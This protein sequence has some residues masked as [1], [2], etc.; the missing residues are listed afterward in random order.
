MSS[1]RP[2]RYLRKNLHRIHIFWETK[3]N[4]RLCCL[5][6]RADCGR[7][8]AQIGFEVLRNLANETLKRQLADEKL[9]RLLIATNFAK[10]N[11]ARAI[12]V[13]SANKRGVLDVELVKCGI[14]YNKISKRHSL[15]HTAGCRRRFARRFSRQLLSRRF[16]AGRFARSLLRASHFKTSC[17]FFVVLKS[18]KNKYNA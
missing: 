8:E 3:F 6:K 5:L 13:R 1:K 14:F 10:R 18:R 16:S 15:F 7:L 12:S 17:E 9:R 4:L 11:G 2:T